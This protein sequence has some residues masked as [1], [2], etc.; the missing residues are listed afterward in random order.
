V[1]TVLEESV[2]RV[3]GKYRVGL[4]KKALAAAGLAKG[5]TVVVVPFR[6][7]VILKAVGTR[8]FTDSLAGFDFREEEHEAS[9]FASKVVKH[10]GP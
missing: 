6:G 8:T 4:G 1:G 2:A 5:G 10:A 9:K 3:D 7:G